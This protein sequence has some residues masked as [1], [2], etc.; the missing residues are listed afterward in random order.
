MS[1]SKGKQATSIDD[2]WA[3]GSRTM[4]RLNIGLGPAPLYPPQ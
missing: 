3:Y 4:L 2:D 1:Y